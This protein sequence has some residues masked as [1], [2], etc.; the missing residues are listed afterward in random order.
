MIKVEAPDL[1]SAILKA[2]QELGCDY[3]EVDYYILQEPITG[4]FGVGK[5][6]AIIIASIRVE[7]GSQPRVKTEVDKSD[8]NRPI[9]SLLEKKDTLLKK[10]SEKIS[11]KD[12]EESEE[13]EKE[14]VDEVKNHINNLLSYTC[15]DINQVVVSLHNSDTLFILFD[16]K[17][18]PL[19]IGREGYRYKSILFVL[20]TWI[21]SRYGLKIQL[22]IG[23]FIKKQNEHIERYLKDEVYEE[24]EKNGFFKTK[25]LDD[26][27]IKLAMKK[28]RERY[29]DRYVKVRNTQSGEK[30]III[31][32]FFTKKV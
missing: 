29:K 30:F 8:I 19:L 20:Q 27:L 6:S 15:F 2:S 3:E 12:D 5:K 21:Q 28:L 7:R 9:K 17:D 22:E 31:D 1:D 4:V 16:G 14:I 25:I 24:V 10:I 26:V 18:A 23:E 11:H 13:R 32:K